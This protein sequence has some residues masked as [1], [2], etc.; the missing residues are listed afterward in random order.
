MK[1]PE[2]L[3][4]RAVNACVYLR[5]QMLPHY[6]GSSSESSSLLFEFVIPARGTEERRRSMAEQCVQSY[7]VVYNTSAKDILHCGNMNP[8]AGTKAYRCVE[9]T[10]E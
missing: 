7:V 1:V 4:A 8:D 2:R 6:S 9:S 3:A 10:K 5:P